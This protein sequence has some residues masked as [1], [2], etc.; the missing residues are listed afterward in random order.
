M[1]F[2]SCAGANVCTVCVLVLWCCVRVCFLC[3]VL[4]RLGSDIIFSV[5]ASFHLS[6]AV[7]QH[8]SITLVVCLVCSV[9]VLLAGCLLSVSVSTCPPDCAAQI[10]TLCVRVCVLCFWS[11]FFLLCSGAKRASVRRACRAGVYMCAR[12]RM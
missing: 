10:I 7:L 2:F 3:V 1:V 4:L 6:T 12:K 9:V 8:F 11:L 5:A